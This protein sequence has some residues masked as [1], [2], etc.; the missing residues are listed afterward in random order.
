MRKYCKLNKIFDAIILATPDPMISNS[1]IIISLLRTDKGISILTV[2]ATAIGLG[3]NLNVYSISA[4][5]RLKF[6]LRT[7]ALCFV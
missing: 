4:S 7:V 2:T 5:V 1:R 6:L 3:K